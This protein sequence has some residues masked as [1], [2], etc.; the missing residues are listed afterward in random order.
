MCRLYMLAFDHSKQNREGRR[1]HLKSLC[2][3][4]TS[5]TLSRVKK[6]RPVPPVAPCSGFLP[7]RFRGARSA[8]L[9]CCRAKERSAKKRKETSTESSCIMVLCRLSSYTRMSPS[10]SQ[11]LPAAFRRIL[12]KPDT[13]S[14]RHLGTCSRSVRSQ[15]LH[16]CLLIVGAATD[17]SRSL[18]LETR[19]CFR[20][21]V[22]IYLSTC[23][24]LR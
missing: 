16:Q 20:L 4:H 21:D 19:N 9:L 17:N 5:Q 12:Y 6:Q 13:T 1:I 14:T 3:V 11:T 7:P 15:E 10:G 22:P 2:F 23:L 24:S 18:S 8:G